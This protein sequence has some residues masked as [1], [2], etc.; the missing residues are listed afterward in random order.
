MA[1]IT[2]HSPIP[3]QEPHLGEWSIGL[4]GTTLETILKLE[5]SVEPEP[6]ETAPGIQMFVTPFDQSITDRIPIAMLQVSNTL[7]RLHSSLGCVKPMLR[8]QILISHRPVWIPMESR[9]AGSAMQTTNLEVQAV[10]RPSSRSTSLVSFKK[11]VR[12][13]FSN[14]ISGWLITALP[15]NWLGRDM[16]CIPAT[17]ET[18]V[19][20]RPQTFSSPP[21][22]DN[23]AA[24]YASFHSI[25]KPCSWADM[26]HD[27]A[28][29]ALTDRLLDP[30]AAP[31]SQW[32]SPT[33]HND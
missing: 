9:R 19:S 27:S 8:W 28:Q 5:N 18:T 20:V 23:V 2:A 25:R 12:N 16:P 32:E 29:K 26:Q 17:A 33:P 10:G 13:T 30:T 22:L 6:I 31:S 4:V 3:T 24:A 21:D 1:E 7:S 11:A 15:P 14:L